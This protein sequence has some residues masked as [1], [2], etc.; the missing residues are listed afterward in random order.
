MTNM[1]VTDY[2][3]RV[4]PRH[5][6]YGSKAY[7]VSCFVLKFEAAATQNEK[8]TGLAKDRI[9]SKIDTLMAKML[10]TDIE[11]GTFTGHIIY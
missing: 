1:L 10:S 3:N 5:V 7:D 2:Q 9:S 11:F 4:Q 6:G 8:V